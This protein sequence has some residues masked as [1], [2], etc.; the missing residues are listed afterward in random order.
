MRCRY[1]SLFW[2][3]LT[4]SPLVTAQTDLAQPDSVGQILQE[5]GR[6]EGT[7]DPK[8]YATAS[9]LEDFMFGTPLSA[10]ARQTKN[11]LQK[12]LVRE[13]WLRAATNNPSPATSTVS[14]A[15]SEAAITTMLSYSLADDGHWTIDFG[16]DRSIRINK[17]D[18]RQYSSIAYSLRA[19]LAVQQEALLA[20]DTRLRPLDPASIP[21][22][23]N[24]VDLYTLSVLKV[25]DQI[26][27]QKNKRELLPADIVSVWEELGG[28]QQQS[29]DAS[30]LA[31]TIPTG[32]ADLTL[33]N[34]VIDQKVASYRE[35]NQVSNQLFVRNLQVYF[36]RN[37]WPATEQEA[38]ALR[39]LFT[40]TLIVIARELYLGAQQLALQRGSALIQEQDVATFLRSYLP[41]QINEYEDA[42]FFPRLPRE[43]QVTI[44]AY[45][46]DA[47]RDSGIHWRYLQF[48]LQSDGFAATLEPDPFALELITENIAQ[49]GVLLLRLTGDIGAQQ[50]A[51]RIS[52]THLTS[53]T[54]LLHTRV[55]ANNKASAVSTLPQQTALSSAPATTAPAASTLFTDV[56][57]ASGVN[58]MHRSSDWLSRLLRSYLKKDETTGI[59]TIPPAF[60]GS[61]I[62]A[63]DINNDG[64][65]DLLLVGGLGNRLYI[66]R[67]EG[68]F[69][70]ITDTAGISWQRADDKTHGEARQPII[71]DFDNDGLQDILITY[72]DDQHRLYR[73]LGNETFA[74][75]TAQSGL[76]G[77]GKVGGPATVFDYDNDGLL[78][79]YVTYFGNYLKGVLPT[80]ARRNTNGEANRLFRN[81][82]N[83][84]F[85]DVTADS[86]LDNN[87]WGQAVTHTDFDKDGLQ[88]V[89]VGNDFGVNAYY[90]NLGGGRFRDIAGE[91]G[92]DKPSYTMGI[93]LADLND[94][95]FPDIYISN[96]VTMNKDQKYVLPSAD[97]PMEFNPDKLANMRV[98]EAND[99]FISSGDTGL[100]TYQS[101]DAV[102]RGYSATGWSWGA[103]FFDS[104]NDG[105]DDLYVVNGMNEFNV[106]SSDNPYYTD[107]LTNQSK[108]IHIPVSTRETNIF[109]LN[110][111]GKL[112]NVSQG[113]GLDLLGNSRSAAYLDIDDDGD[114]DI[115]LNN[116]H[117]QARVYR[118]DS[119]SDHNAWLKVKLEG[120]PTQGVNRDAIGAR[121]ILR[122]ADGNRVW[123]EI[124]GSSGYMTV[125]PKQQHFGLGNHASAALEVVWPNG[126]RQLFKN[127]AA[128]QSVHI[129]Y[130]DSEPRTVTR[131]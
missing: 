119:A 12:G 36:A 104:D 122:T 100:P 108:N 42:I 93:G 59:I 124:H 127:I 24:V 31:A 77:K 18:K 98:V 46:M 131:P 86:G 83:F 49:I 43:Q 39:R 87:G 90:R 66:N 28:G 80:L 107:P 68:V 54:A 38:N 71:A 91:L 20:G 102:E 14:P 57:A 118:N 10:E 62:A 37:R 23:R 74:D 32:A 73:N 110:Q 97:T 30:Q 63:G 52:S 112:N 21:L 105:D 44:E 35:Y 47:F 89:I 92:T 65:S 95:L 11:E 15:A 34:A 5:I 72:V 116:Y 26:A 126:E 123:R 115:A 99:L 33:A 70:D 88:D 76:G 48:A 75:V 16:D 13:I 129:R 53:A 94:D 51:K 117:E 96:I 114:L 9:R 128:N 3:F 27:R 2:L 109:F 29:P 82:G 85:A 106:Y 103:E 84:T 125:Q 8:C 130:G 58:Y 79:V 7:S 111:D 6:L 40:E 121:L 113:S 67:G 17:T 101:S 4:I 60:G 61:G 45:D 56:T 64:R 78:D 1:L 25:A 22:I 55:T 50:N 81:T 69:E 19:L 120:A 41:H